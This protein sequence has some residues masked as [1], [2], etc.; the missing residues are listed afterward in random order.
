[1]CVWGGG[2]CC[3]S[4]SVC[5]CVVAMCDSKRNVYVRESEQRESVCVV[6]MS[7]GE[8]VWCV[9]SMHDSEKKHNVSVREREREGGER[10]RVRVCVCERERVSISLCVLNPWR[11]PLVGQKMAR[12]Q[13]P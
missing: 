12:G 10:E 7:L 4:V 5:L 11:G 1:M 8:S 2:G 6:C 9:V 13:P 3:M